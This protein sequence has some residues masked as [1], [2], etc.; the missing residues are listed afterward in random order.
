MLHIQEKITDFMDWLIDSI[1]IG[2][3]VVL[4]L[5][6][7]AVGAVICG[8]PF[9]YNWPIL[10]AV[11]VISIGIIIAVVIVRAGGHLMDNQPFI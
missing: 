2:I 8:A 9:I 3:G 6:G 5:H 4:A 7:I 11:P 1:R 10:A